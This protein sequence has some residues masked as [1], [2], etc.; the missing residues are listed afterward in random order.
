MCV[1]VS[2]HC[3][4]VCLCCEIERAACSMDFL[5]SIIFGQVKIMQLLVPLLKCVKVNVF[6]MLEEMY[7]MG[8]DPVVSSDF[9]RNG[10][11]ATLIFKKVIRKI[12]STQILKC[13]CIFFC[14]LL[15]NKLEQDK[16]TSFLTRSH[17]SLYLF[18]L[19]NFF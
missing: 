14:D 15:S 17:T 16:P 5:G 11:T 2:V 10:E 9:A 18:L 19:R 8:Y 1:Y 4:I 3:V 6:R 7:K 12:S 13:I